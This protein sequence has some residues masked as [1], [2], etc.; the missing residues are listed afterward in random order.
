VRPPGRIG[1]WQCQPQRL[2]A[3]MTAIERLWTETRTPSGRP[4]QSPRRHGSRRRRGQRRSTTIPNHDDP[5]SKR[6]GTPGM[7][8]WGRLG[9]Y[10]SCLTIAAGAAAVISVSGAEAAAEPLGTATKPWL[11]GTVARPDGFEHFHSCASPRGASGLCNRL[12]CFAHG[13]KNPRP[14]SAAPP[15]E[16]P[17]LARKLV[18]SELVACVNIVPGERGAAVRVWMCVEGRCLSMCERLHGS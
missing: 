18:A 1:E 12:V 2:T 16:A 14:C 4:A 3:Y 6:A 11:A 13:F 8:P 7:I 15:S 9:G 5:R 10:R 17:E